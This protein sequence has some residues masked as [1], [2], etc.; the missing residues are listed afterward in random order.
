MNRFLVTAKTHRRNGRIVQMARIVNV[1][2]GS[3]VK[4]AA[5]VAALLALDGRRDKG[6]PFLGDGVK[7][8]PLIGPLME[9]G[10]PVDFIYNPDT[11][12]LERKR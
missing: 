8:I 2:F 11:Y 5:L 10:K 1:H 9:H 12:E 7:V 6:L 4:D 3:A